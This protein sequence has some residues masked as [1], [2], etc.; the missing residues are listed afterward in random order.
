MSDS[1]RP[2]RRQP[3]RLLHPWDSPGKNTG[4]GCHFLLQCIKV[5][6]ESEV[7]QLCPTLCDPVDYSLPGSS[8]HGIFQARVLEWG[9][10][11][12]N[13]NQFSSL[14]S[15][16]TAKSYSPA[17]VLLSP[18]RQWA[19]NLS[20]VLER[21]AEPSATERVYT[22]YVWAVWGRA[23]GEPVWEWKPEL[24]QSRFMNGTGLLECISA[25]PWDQMLPEGA[26]L[27]DAVPDG[28]APATH[29]ACDTPTLVWAAGLCWCF[30]FPASPH[31]IFPQ[32]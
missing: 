2:H 30:G 20:S 21:G 22:S 32:V 23:L 3:T 26:L 25:P 4:V 28:R 10:I 15:F 6:S 19:Y 17:A 24:T 29:A 18:E 14:P 7:T 13:S 11:A 8:I 12:H 31:S 27:V 16:P 5:K 1:V 9:A